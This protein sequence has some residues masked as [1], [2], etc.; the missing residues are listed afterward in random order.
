M[1]INSKLQKRVDAIDSDKSKIAEIVSEIKSDGVVQDNKIIKVEDNIKSLSTSLNTFKKTNKVNDAI[2]NGLKKQI[3]DIQE[4]VDNL[5]TTASEV[6]NTNNSLSYADIVKNGGGIQKLTDKVL[7]EA[8]IRNL[9][10]VNVIITGLDLDNLEMGDTIQSKVNDL[11]STISEDFEIINSV[12]LFSKRDNKLTNKVVVTLPS[13]EIRDNLIKLSKPILRGQ[14]I[15]INPDLT[16]MEMEVEYK[17]RQ[18]K[19]K[20]FSLLPDDE[21]EIKSYYIRNNSIFMYHKITKKHE[22]VKAI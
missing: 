8:K 1:K 10:E 6:G 20:L 4:T 3:A 15:F 2:H 9:K 22:L 5:K 16:S 17:L 21:K 19:K 12:Q 14:S 11:L 18:E 13:K 7:N